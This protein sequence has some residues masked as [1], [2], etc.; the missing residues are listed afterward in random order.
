MKKNK[1]MTLS[2]PIY[3]IPKDKIKACLD[4]VLDIMKETDRIEAF[5]ME[6]GSTDITI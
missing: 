3:N 2:I 5:I 4:S 6:N 1:L